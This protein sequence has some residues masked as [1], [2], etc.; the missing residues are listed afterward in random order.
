MYT[1][2]LSKVAGLTRARQVLQQHHPCWA[3]DMTEGWTGPAGVQDQ[4][5]RHPASELRAGPGQACLP[6]RCLAPPPR[7]GSAGL[8][9]AARAPFHSCD[10]RDNGAPTSVSAG[11]PGT[12]GLAAAPPLPGAHPGLQPAGR[13]GCPGHLQRGTDRKSLQRGNGGVDS[14]GLS[15]AVVPSVTPERWSLTN[16]GHHRL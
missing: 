3:V 14:Q 15:W 2:S 16:P 4:A 12:G 6:H 8:A 13:L 5:G 11:G 7:P 10:S 9:R 1:G